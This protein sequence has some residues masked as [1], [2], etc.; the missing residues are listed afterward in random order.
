MP[1]SKAKR[2]KKHVPKEVRKD[3]MAF[4][5]SGLTLIP[6]GQKATIE[7]K[8]HAAIFKLRSGVGTRE[9]WD[10]VVGSINMAQVMCE[11]GTGKE[12]R[13]MIIEGSKALLAV[14][15][16][17]VK[18]GK[19]EFCGDELEKLVNAMEVHDAQLSVARVIDM[20]HATNE[21]ARRIG[22][23]INV[24]KVMVSA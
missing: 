13:E 1:K 8:N 7:T 2:C 23:N 5:K 24:Q 3:C 11:L 15:R 19:F 12:Y 16:R 14:G 4:V 22:K 9:D 10:L 21:V 18:W 20:E 17:Y 6:E